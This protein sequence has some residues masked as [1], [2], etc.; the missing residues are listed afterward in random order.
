MRDER[1]ADS[2]N[3]SAIDRRGWTRHA[4]DWG[5]PVGNPK[6]GNGCPGP[7]SASA[8][9]PPSEQGGR[10]RG[11]SGD[12]SWKPRSIHDGRNSDQCMASVAPT[13]PAEAVSG[14]GPCIHGR[15]GGRA[16]HCQSARRSTSAAW[17][18]EAWLDRIE[19]PQRPC[20]RDGRA[21]VCDRPHAA[22]HARQLVV[23]VGVSLG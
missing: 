9:A 4:R 11:T 5:A 3:G 7:R 15:R 16:A 20:G 13:A 18:V 1:R 12:V 14:R 19:L 23:A 2:R 17:W 6:R 8:S 10:A 22:A 21:H